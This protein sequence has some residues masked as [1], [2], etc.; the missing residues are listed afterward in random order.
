MD[1]TYEVLPEDVWR[2]NQ[3]YRRKHALRPVIVYGVVAVIALI[4][5]GLVC[6][7]LT[8]WQGQ[9]RVDMSQMLSLAL[10]VYVFWRYLPPSK[11]RVLKTAKQ[12]PGFL[13][14]HSV[15]LSP[16]WISEKTNVSDSK[17]AWITLFSLEEDVDH[18][19]FFVNKASA[20]I[21]PKR[22]FSSPAKAQA[23]LNEARRYWSAAKSG[24]TVSAEDRT[25]W[26]PPPGRIP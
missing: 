23:F 7:L 24:A 26:P 1:I 25:V 21:I 10:V 15:A 3:Y 9:G 14:K 17:A 20:L 16:D 8:A 12:T 6:M 18:L 22:A 4:S 19:F 11:A 2:L 5:L 13:G